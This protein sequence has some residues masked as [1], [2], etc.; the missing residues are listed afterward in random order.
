MITGEGV[1]TLALVDVSLFALR[2]SY[3]AVARDD[4]KGKLSSTLRMN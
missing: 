4:S 1:V 3:V 2:I